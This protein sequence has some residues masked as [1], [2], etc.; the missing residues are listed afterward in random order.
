[1]EHFQPTTNLG[2][3]KKSIGFLMEQRSYKKRTRLF[4]RVRDPAENEIEE[5][6]EKK[7]NHK[8]N[9]FLLL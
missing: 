9:Y 4:A 5:P 3:R 6:Q 2:S 8:R 7:Y 1:M